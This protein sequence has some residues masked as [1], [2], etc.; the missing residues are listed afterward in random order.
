[1][2]CSILLSNISYLINSF[3]AQENITINHSVSIHKFMVN[4]NIFGIV[5]PFLIIL[6]FLLIYKFLKIKSNLHD[7]YVDSHTRID[8][9][10]KETQFYFLFLGIIIPVLEIV[11][12]FLEIRSKDLLIK[13]CI[14]GIS[15]LT[16]YFISKKSNLV[17]QNIQYI[18]K[19][20]F[21]FGFYTIAHNLIYTSPDIIPLIAFVIWFFF[22]YDILKPLKLYWFS[23][24]AVFIYIYVLFAF[25]IIPLKSVSLL[26]NYCLLIQIINYVR[27]KSL[28]SVKDKF[29][30]SDE[31]VNK[32]NALI[33]ATNNAGEI[34]FCSDT[35]TSILGYTTDE[36]KGFGFWELTEDPEFIGEKYHESYIDE[37]LYVRKLKCKNGSYKYIQWRDKKHNENLTIGIG[38]DITNEIIFQNQYRD[39][40]QNATDLI[41]EVDCLGNFTF[42]NDFTVKALGYSSDEALTRNYS[43]FI[44]K[45]YVKVM[46]D[47]YQNI[48]D[49]D[50]G[51]RT[52]EIPLLKKDG[53]EMWISQKVAIR[54]N[55]FGEIIGYSG[56]AR[57]ITALK[58]I[59]I[60]KQKKQ[61]KIDQYNSAIKNLSIKNFNK[62]ENLN[63]I[64]GT[65]IKVAAKA[66]NTNRV[67]FWKFK[68]N[69]II[70]K[71]LYLLDE[72]KFSKKIS[73]EKE[74]CPIY[75]EFLKNESQIVITDA[76]EKWK[77]IE[78][79]CDYIL[80]YNIKSMLYIS[81]FNN[82]ELTGAICFETTIDKKYWDNDDINFARTISDIIS[83]QIA[84]RKRYQAEINLEYKSELLSAMALC[85]EKFLL[86]K[87]I[88]EMFIETYEIMG[89]A[90]KADHLFYHE[91]DLSTNLISQKFKWAK[92]GNP[93]Q[94]NKLNGFRIE[95]IKELFT[96][97]N[98][99]KYF[100]CITRKLK[101]SFLK[102]LLQINEI[103]SILIIPIYIENEFIGFIS[104]DDCHHEKKWSND[105][106]NILQTLAHNI[107]SAMERN[108]N[109][110]IL[111]ESQEKF[112]LLANNI[113]G[114][115]YLSN[116]DDKWSKIYIND[117]IEKL[118]GYDKEDFL[119]NKLY[120][121][122]LVHPED[123]ERVLISAK[124]LVEEHIKVQ[125]IY[126]IIHKN[127]H[128][129]WVEEFGDSIKKD[130]VIH[131][132]GGI[133]FD[134]TKKK[135]AEEA[136]IAKEIAEAA[137]KAK[138]EFIA[139]MS[140]EIRTPLNGIIGFTDLLMKTNLEKTQ[141]KHMITVNQSAHSLLDIINNILDFSKIEAGKLELFIEKCE[142]KEILN[143]TIDLISYESNLKNLK[144]ELLITSDLPKFLW[145]DIVRLK[146]ILINL[147]ANAVK[148]TEKGSI[149]L[150][151]SLLEKTDDYKNKIRFSVIDSGIGILEENKNKIFEAFS[152]E[153]NSTTRKFGGTG[154]GLSISN[155]L[156]ALMNSNLQ[157]ES[158]IDIGSTFYFDLDLK[159]SNLAT[160]DE[161]KIII[162]TE[163]RID[164]DIKKIDVLKN[165]K[166]MIAE[167]NKINMLLIK[168]IIKNIFP[169]ITIFEVFNGKDAV[170]QFESINPDIV[171]MDIQMPLMNGYEATK[172]IRNLES[173]KKIPIIAVTAGVEKEEKIKCMQAGMND[174][175]S[176]PIMKGAIEETIIKWM[177]LPKLKPKGLNK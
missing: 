88:D 116:I 97:I 66:T 118:T 74:N 129:V 13:N 119:E 52:I 15:L 20:T 172:A 113:P 127:G 31:I 107:S 108:K 160:K 123:K 70:C 86:S 145:V 63:D 6:A 64:I 37:R 175:L 84:S 54:R 38:N 114:T 42:I 47:F 68:K 87:S 90:T 89:K 16:I 159:T 58:N 138:S 99:N 23:V 9:R 32:G 168:T 35:I 115:V 29:K 142:I 80:N 144:L 104:F 12:V 79:V 69:K 43:E 139:N 1:M 28:L 25:E 166:I 49:K 93:L 158:K 76:N 82:G 151:V 73:L 62:F 133:F 130:N 128:I 150:V 39:L 91:I 3:F 46:I 92:K 83:L 137:N 94:T 111:Y 61:E 174:H 148:F 11:F 143:Q 106:I 141:E 112:R 170:E 30:F 124:K 126:R 7:K 40:I 75:F 149:Q 140:H 17:F 51:F 56:F 103:K 109:E 5:S 154:L 132:V 72:N 161:L 26:F 4:N 71:K 147:L 135:E 156:L 125:I 27:H 18:F 131:Y 77:D 121:V 171:F 110:T 59:E 96:K 134:I 48:P 14:L 95:D 45:D 102:D 78:F 33:I 44:R 22:S 55:D 34:S 152:Q 120:Y 67:S 157:L 162:P 117:E 164:I 19:I 53:S 173:G 41:F 177:D 176:K 2:L 57:D 105:E 163:N 81:I 146:Q 10:N 169:E 21:L 167:D 101:K 122:D 155:Q 65:I 36:V 98:K 100:K 24:A 165:L 60:E 85:T 136:L 50:D 8:S 153:D